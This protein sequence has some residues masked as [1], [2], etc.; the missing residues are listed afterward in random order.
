MKKDEKTT[1]TISVLIWLPSR[2]DPAWGSSAFCIV[3]T[4]W[5]DGIIQIMHAEEYQRPDYNEML[6]TVHRLIV[7][8][9][10]DRTYVDG[11]NPSFI[12]SLKLMLGE[13]PNY[14]KVIDRN[15]DE[16]GRE[17]ESTA[18]DSN[19]WIADIMDIVPVNFRTQHKAMLGHC[20]F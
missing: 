16:R 2:W 14:E 5:V 19:N 7:R 12:R 3:V 4:Q 18:D 9:G 1:L 8:Y 13:N 17:R 6:S 20:N 11:A 15:R 10:V